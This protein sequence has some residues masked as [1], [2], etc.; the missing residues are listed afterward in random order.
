MASTELTIK[1]VTRRLRF[2]DSPPR[3]S[4]ASDTELNHVSKDNY[5]QSAA[6]LYAKVLNVFCCVL[7]ISLVISF[8]MYGKNACKLY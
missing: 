3:S 2:G 6:N 4:R 8:G 5:Q 1:S 7:M